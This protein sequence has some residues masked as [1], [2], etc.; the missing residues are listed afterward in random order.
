LPETVQERELGF[1]AIHIVKNCCFSDFHA[2]QFPLGDRHLLDIELFG[3][4]L[5]RP[6]NFQVVAK[7]IEFGAIFARQHDGAGAETVTEGV[8][9]NCSFTLG[10]LG[11]SRFLRV[12]TVGLELFE[13]CHRV[14][15]CQQSQIWDLGEGF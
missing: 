13:R 2:D 11:A 3:P 15:P 12:A 5:R 4:R 6:F 9:A 14:Y 1:G 7:L 10:S 8:H